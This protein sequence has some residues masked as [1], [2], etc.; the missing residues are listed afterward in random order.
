M[1]IPK[2]KSPIHTKGRTNSMGGTARVIT[3]LY[4]IQCV[5]LSILQIFKIRYHHVI[6]NSDNK[7][8]TIATDYKSL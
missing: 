7:E 6:G 5:S 4:S 3:S 1:N 8:C 2:D